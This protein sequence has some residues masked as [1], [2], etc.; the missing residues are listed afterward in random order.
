MDI[1]NNANLILN[2]LCES[3]YEAY[4]VGGCVRDFLMNRPC[5]DFDITTCAKPFE[6]EEALSR[7]GI[8]Y[9]ETGLK[10]GTVTAV[11]D[12]EAFEITTYRTDGEYLDARHPENVVFVSDLSEDL[13]RRD[14]SINALAYNAKDGIVDKFGGIDDIKNGIIRTVGNPDKRFNED[15]LRIMRA[16]RF[17]STLGFAIENETAVSVHK[18]AEL[19]KNISAERI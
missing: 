7:K 16:L 10:H 8:R 6:I 11:I 14:F 17:A 12:G 15:A 9:F 18:N 19:L 5:N 4:F 1:P 3:G 2:A 13:S